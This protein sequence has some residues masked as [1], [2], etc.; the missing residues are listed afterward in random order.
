MNDEDVDFILLFIFVVKN[1][2]RSRA[3]SKSSLKNGKNLS[4]NEI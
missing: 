3:I 4:L 1:R 2:G